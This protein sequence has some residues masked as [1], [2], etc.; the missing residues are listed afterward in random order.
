MNSK[1]PDSGVNPHEPRAFASVTLRPLPTDPHPSA[2]FAPANGLRDSGLVRDARQ[3]TT[4][5]TPATAIAI[6]RRP[7]CSVDARVCYDPG[8]RAHASHKLPC[9][10]PACSSLHT[11]A[12]VC[13]GVATHR[14]GPKLSAPVVDGAS[15]PA[16]ASPPSIAAYGA[17]KSINRA[18]SGASLVPAMQGARIASCLVHALPCRLAPIESASAAC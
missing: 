8:C 9:E 13:S 5:P 14:P 1:H 3:R 7:C 12:W 4:T 10:R 15:S 16:G 2:R 17:Q 11:A 18:S 6:A